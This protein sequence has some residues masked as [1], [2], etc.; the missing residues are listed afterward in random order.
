MENYFE[1]LVHSA[2]TARVL[3]GKAHANGALIE[4]LCLYVVIIDA[5][6]RLAIIYT[7]TQN[8]PDHRY[9]VHKNLIYQDEGERTFSEKQIYA[10]AHDEKI[11]STALYEQLLKMYS[12]R[13]KVVH[14]FALSEI[15]YDEIGS[16]CIEFEHVYQK[17][18]DLLVVLEHGPHGIREPDS[19][20]RTK[21]TKA[22]LRKV[23]L[24]K[25]RT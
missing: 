5:F 10:L 21:A 24:K 3:L 20:T 15:T 25:P 23:G 6:L 13:N 22:I 11:I 9:E 12:F 17:L 8:A 7:R 2:G 18:F 16:A 19:Q 1:N 14:R 4:G